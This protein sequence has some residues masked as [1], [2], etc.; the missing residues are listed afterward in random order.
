MMVFLVALLILLTGAEA[1]HAELISG[2]AAIVIGGLGS[3]GST[4]LGLL[5]IGAKFLMSSLMQKEPKDRGVKLEAENGADKPPKIILGD[6]ATPGHLLYHN[7]YGDDR[8]RYVAVYVLSA[9]PVQGLSNLLEVNG[10]TCEIDFTRT[11]DFGMHPV[12]EYE[13]GREYLSIKF[14]D[15]TQ[16]APDPFLRDV[17]G[18]DDQF[19]WL[20]DML[21]K[22]CAYVVIRA[23][24]SKE[25]VWSGSPQFLF[26]VKG[27]RLY[28]FRKDSTVAG[29][30]G[31]QRWT[32]PSTW[33][34]NGYKNPVIQK[35][36]IIRGI[37][38]NGEVIWG[39][40]AE[41]WRLPL[42][43][44]IAAANAADVEIE[45]K[46]GDKIPAFVTGA[47]IE[48]DDQPIEFIKVLD[49]CHNG[50]TTEFGGIYKAYCG[51]P[52]LSVMTLTD[53]DFLITEKG[54]DD[55]F[56]TLEETYNSGVATHPI[57]K[58]GWVSD[59]T[60]LY[61]NAAALSADD[62]NESMLEADLPLVAE[63][64]QA[65][66]IL[67]AMILDSRAQNKHS[68]VLPPIAMILEPHD[69]VSYISTREGYAGDGEDFIIGAKAHLP[70][71]N[72][73]VT[74]RGINA[75]AD[76]W[77]KDMEMDKTVGL[78]GRIR[79]G[80]LALDIT[81]ATSWV[82]S[83]RG[84]DKP[85]I[86]AEWDWGDIDVDV[87][88]LDWRI[89]LSGT[90]EIIAQGAITEL[91]DGVQKIVHRTLRFGKTYQ[92]Q[93]R[94]QPISARKTNWTAWQSVTL[95]NLD[96][97][98]NVVLTKRSVIA[99]DGTL[100][101][102]VKIDWNSISGEVDYI[103]EITDAD[104]DI[105]TRRTDG[106][107]Y[108]IKVSDAGVISVRVR[109]VANDDG[110]R[111]PWTNPVSLNITAKNTAPIAPAALTIEGGYR[112]IVLTLP[113]STEKD[114][115]FVNVYASAS[116]DFT[117]AARIGRGAPGGVF[118]HK[119]ANQ[120]TRYYWCTFV[121][122]TTNESAKFPS[123]NTGGR[124][125]TTSKITDDDFDDSG[126]AT[127]TGLALTA[128][129]ILADDGWIDY[130]IK[131]QWN[132]I[133]NAKAS[134][135]LR[136]YD[137]TDYDYYNVSPDGATVR[138]WFAAKPNV[139][140]TASVAAKNAGGVVG[141]FSGN[142]TITPTKKALL[143][144]TPAGL[145]LTPGHKRNKLKWTASPDSDYKETVIYRATSN[146]FANAAEVDRKSGR[147]CTDD[148][149]TNG[150]TY[151]YW[152]S[153]VDRSGNESAK[154][155]TSNTAGVS[156]TPL[157][158]YADD[159]DQT[160][161]ATPAA[162][163]AIAQITA[164]IDGDGSIDTA[165][166]L[167][168]TQP[169]SGVPVKY[170]EVELQRSS[171]SGG[172]YAAFGSRVLVPA[173][174]SGDT[175]Y[176][177]KVNQAKFYKARY[178][179]ISFSG[180]KGTYSALTAAGVQPLAYLGSIPT[181]TLTVTPKAKGMF[182]KW[183]P[184]TSN[185]YLETIVFR[186]GVEIN[187]IKA[188]SFTDNDELSSGTAYSYSVQHIDK[189]NRVGA[190]SGAVSATYRGVQTT[191]MSAGSVTASVTDATALSA[192]SCTNSVGTV[193][194]GAV[195]MAQDNQDVNG[196]GTVDIAITADWN[197]VA[198]AVR[199]DVE[200]SSAASSGG[201][202]SVTGLGGVAPSGTT[203]FTFRANTNKFYKVRVRARNAFGAPGNWTTSIVVA[204][205]STAFSSFAGFR[206][207]K[208]PS[209]STS[210]SVGMSSVAL[211]IRVYFNSWIEDADYLRTDVFFSTSPT[212]TLNQFTIPTCVIS[213]AA[214]LTVSAFQNVDLWAPGQTVYGWY[215]NVD[216]SGNKT[217]WVACVGSPVAALK[218]DGQYISAASIARASLKDRLINSSAL[219]TSAV[220]GRALMTTDTS[221]MIPD[222]GLFDDDSWEMTRCSL[223]DYDDTWRAVRFTDNSYTAEAGSTYIAGA[224]SQRF[225]V[226][227]GTIL[228]YGAV[229]DFNTSLDQ[230]GRMYVRFYD[231]AGVQISSSYYTEDAPSLTA[232]PISSSVVVPD[233]AVTADAYIRRTA[234]VA[235]GG[236]AG[237]WSVYNP[238]VFRMAATDQIPASAVTQKYQA[239]T[240]GSVTLTTTAQTIQSDVVNW[241][242]DYEW[243]TLEASFYVGANASNIPV[244]V[245]LYIGS[246]LLATL[247]TITPAN[248]IV[249][250]KRAFSA[251]AIAAVASGASGTINLTARTTTGTLA[252]S[253]RSLISMVFK[254]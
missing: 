229:F 163:P 195:A 158:I 146:N 66:R 106:S 52:G 126:P 254:R 175:L 45:K 177:V 219:A 252:I 209:Y 41:A 23:M 34:G 185:M 155:P 59:T 116:N 104:G 200:V 94:P 17:F 193:V 100:D 221:N 230:A 133:S 125:A 99:K 16:T 55:P 121:D 42:S 190:A 47:E 189:Q 208:K 183:S 253:T 5:A 68:G 65:Q 77:L 165:L 171:T 60:P 114:V 57:P 137:G 32:D 194:A 138:K 6:W 89:R 93:F 71:V 222:N 170:F 192:P 131:A 153:H 122:R 179:C 251:A 140:F 103:V 239:L 198:G 191:D 61:V 26:G 167:T 30:S 237:T 78:P 211:G 109:A 53:E 243:V 215:R 217:D 54:E 20:A 112:A 84:R 180:A 28:D 232:H 151:Y 250:W 9:I 115:Q 147:S 37:R 7:S 135:I 88:R 136:V 48:L 72:Q 205:T 81:T 199:Y 246:T 206:P 97:P 4:A 242:T 176:D 24:Y 110:T 64:N 249:F 19:P 129:T 213:G 173:E 197:D 227:P 161:P 139:T 181:P 111:G 152:I 105:Q 238:Y 216:R 56:L 172:A 117:T 70:S 196:D 67:R 120:V 124:S 224:I 182:L 46:N 166:R 220:T 18:A 235:G 160:A 202:F 141:A 127:P 80:V 35:Y 74:L 164:D 162:A 27:A 178:R 73:Q 50:Y 174:P 38:Y 248:T 79:T 10:E 247:T 234:K 13:D 201:A 8:S 225:A 14:Y 101:F 245:E 29:G 31:S 11:N 62:G 142:V 218:F 150:V 96:I 36:N 123:S 69:R 49:R 143:P 187:R 157:L 118:A 128:R 119:L 154:H 241:G 214:S 148:G 12:V 90:T 25:G 149:L 58:S 156:G 207:V 83:E 108:K 82:N 236:V 21:V 188:S 159:T 145:A 51:A 15:G 98:G 22:G 40:D 107:S 3:L 63:T 228:K 134:Y 231:L 76:V 92:I 204:S 95:I 1:A 223:I 130:R 203:K 85:A 226:T 169:S 91:L 87:A 86:L 144:T 33:T 184:W 210:I 233:N 102:W 2:I 240:S 44:W 39:G 43:Y 186:D 132:A 168:L 75:E 212:P 244:I 113:E